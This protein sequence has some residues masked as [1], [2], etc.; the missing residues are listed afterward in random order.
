MLVVRRL[1]GASA[2]L[3]RGKAVRANQVQNAMQYLDIV[4]RLF[5]DVLA[6]S[7]TST[8]RW[9]EGPISPGPMEYRR[10]GSPD[11]TVCVWVLKVTEMRL[12]EVAAY[13]GREANWPPDVMLAG[14]REHY[15]GIGLSDIVQVVEHLTPEETKPRLEA[16]M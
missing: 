10:A 16:L 2:T 3:R 1:S 8:I 13:L 5:P 15:P 12:S 4:S 9:R 7:K 11:E 14:M 6:G